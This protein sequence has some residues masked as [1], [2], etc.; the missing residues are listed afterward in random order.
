M[1]QNKDEAWHAANKSMNMHSIGI[2]HEGYA[3]KD[4][5]WYTE[6]Q[7][8]SSAALVKYLAA[9]YDIPLDREHIIGH[10]EVP[11]V[12]DANVRSQHWD[13]GPFWDWNHYMQLLGAPPD[14]GPAAPA[15]CTRPDR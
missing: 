10:D 13:P 6:P 2:E 8:E 4:G 12:L 9:K 5:S 11:G 15:A 7:Y 3:I 14:G 1:V